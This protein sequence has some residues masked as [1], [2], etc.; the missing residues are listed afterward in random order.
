MS[1]CL[2]QDLKGFRW[3]L[4][5]RAATSQM[6]EMSMLT[7]ITG[8]HEHFDMKLNN[9][10]A[11]LLHHNAMMTVTAFCVMT[12]ICNSITGGRPGWYSAKTA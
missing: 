3:C 6:I 10:I 7:P 8:A 5:S 12:V 4:E 1:F 11:Q 2:L 9:S